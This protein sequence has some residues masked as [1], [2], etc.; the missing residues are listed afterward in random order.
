MKVRNLFLITMGKNIIAKSMGKKI[1]H[2]CSRRDAYT[3]WLDLI[4]NLR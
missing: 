4:G 3:S 1:C 2:G